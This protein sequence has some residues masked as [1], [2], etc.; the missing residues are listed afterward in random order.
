MNFK[1]FIIAILICTI[2]TP[3][4]AS[5]RT[6]EGKASGDYYNEVW[7]TWNTY[8][9]RVYVDPQGNFYVHTNVLWEIRCFIEKQRLSKTIESLEK[10]IEWCKKAKDNEIEITKPISETWD[11]KFKVTFYSDN[12]G[13][14]TSTILHLQDFENELFKIELYLKPEQVQELI[15]VLKAVPQTVEE[16]KKQE[17]KAKMLE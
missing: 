10:A 1:I 15:T 6:V 8:P 17:Q 7:K 11:G 3:A 5:S 4:L 12:K 14:Q 13:K 2:I 9:I 16:L